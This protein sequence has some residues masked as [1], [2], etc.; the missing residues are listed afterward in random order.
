MQSSRRAF[1]GSS[2]AVAAAAT[3]T[4][5]QA[6]LGLA[7]GRSSAAKSGDP[8]VDEFIRQIQQA[9]QELTR[10]KGEGARRIAQTLRAWAAYGDARNYN[11]RLTQAANDLMAKRGRAA[12]IF[13]TPNHAEMERDAERLGLKGLVD[14]HQSSEPA[15]RETALNTLLQEG[16]TPSLRR[17]ADVLEKGGKWL[18][19]HQMSVQPVAF[20]RSCS[21]DDICIG[22]TMLKTE[23]DVIC[24]IS[25]L[26]PPAADLCAAI[27]MAWL[28]MAGMC[29]ICRYALCW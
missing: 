6:S 7:Q 10:G 18:D 11:R 24:A 1:M 25:A 14:V 5:F 2:A 16:L 17:A 22:A 13:G 21:C 23:M 15:A 3:A 29:S 20:A 27:G 28:T 8:V 12:I 19:E 9:T 26:F 4:M